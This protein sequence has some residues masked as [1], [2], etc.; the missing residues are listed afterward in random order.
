M[1]GSLSL[2]KTF[3]KETLIYFGH[4]YTLSNAKFCIKHDPD[5]ENLKKKIDLI[6]KNIE[7]GTPT[8]PSVLKEELECNIFLRAENIE[9]FSKL[10]DLK[11]NF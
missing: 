5:N 9:T 6:N 2:I 3:N 10:R 11:D 1:F 7:A 8:V 4:E